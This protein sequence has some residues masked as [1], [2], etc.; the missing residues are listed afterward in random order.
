MAGQLLPDPARQPQRRPALKF[1]SPG[2]GPGGCSSGSH[3]L[4]Q[5]SDLG[6]GQPAP[7]AF[8]QIRPQ[9][10]TA[11]GRTVQ[12]LHPIAHRGHHALDLVV[13]ALGESQPQVMLARCRTSLRPDRLRV[14]VQHHAI[15]QALHHLGGQR[16]LDLCFVHLGHMVARRG[17]AVDEFAVVRHQ[18]QAR[19]VLVQTAHRLHPGRR[20][21]AAFAQGTR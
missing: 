14:I 1:V 17:H 5:R 13:L 6:F 11:N 20:P 15:Q 19:G 7:M 9:R 21:T 16:M 2:D 18:K 4:G 12:G 10:Q 8:R 3:L